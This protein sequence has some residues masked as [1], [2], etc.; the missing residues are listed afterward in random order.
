[1]RWLGKF[2]LPIGLMIVFITVIHGH[3]VRIGPPEEDDLAIAESDADIATGESVSIQVNPEK[4]E[5][6]KTGED[7]VIQEGKVR[8]GDVAVF[9]GS[10]LVRGRINGDLVVFG[11]NVNISGTVTG[12]VVIFAGN[13]T[14]NNTA[15]I[16][17][18]LVSLGGNISREEGSYIGKN[19]L[20]LSGIPM[21][22][23]LTR[24]ISKSTLEDETNVDVDMLNKEST[25]KGMRTFHGIAILC[26]F[27]VLVACLLLMS[28]NLEQSSKVMNHDLLKSLLFGFLF[29]C[30]TLFTMI[31][32][33]LTL[34]GIPL[35]LL[36]IVFWSAVCAFAVPVGCIALGKRVL[37]L[38]GR[39]NSSIVASS[40]LGFTI[41]S[42][43]RFL[44][45]FLGFVI[46][47]IWAMA[48]IGATV[49]SKFGMM[50]PWFKK[51]LPASDY[52]SHQIIA[53]RIL[54]PNPDSSDFSP[55]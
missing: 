31:L 53:P 21:M 24:L 39:D 27:I 18:S 36:L 30:A 17:G 43:F 20:D 32:L 45:F 16:D 37:D 47:H 22:S 55:R 23:L 14:L 12:D 40:M 48:A 33:I 50:K 9:G 2:I 13:I 5:T 7:L 26:W 38:F 11:G 49:S 54:P 8:E 3:P 28:R 19:E 29:H 1:M 4:I 41:L 44:P 25:R 52:P 6:L 42:L 15:H 46:W 34:I 51:G 10:A 35:S